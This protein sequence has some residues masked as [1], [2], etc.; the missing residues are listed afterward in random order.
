MPD[1]FI[2]KLMV[3]LQVVDD[4]RD[5]N[6][7]WDA[8]LAAFQEAAARLVAHPNAGRLDAAVTALPVGD[9]A[10]M[11]SFI[12]VVKPSDS[13]ASGPLFYE[14]VKV[15]GQW[16]VAELVARANRGYAEMRG[17]AA[18][19]RWGRMSTKDESLIAKYLGRR[20]IESGCWERTEQ[21]G[22]LYWKYW[23]TGRNPAAVDMDEASEENASPPMASQEPVDP[24]VVDVVGQPECM[25]LPS[26]D[27]SEGEQA[28]V[29]GSLETLEKFTGESNKAFDFSL[30]EHT[31]Q[32][33]A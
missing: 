20:L 8:A 27:S 29:G 12:D 7:E 15:R 32:V 28:S 1:G 26:A 5:G 17:V 18:L 31:G 21:E 23:R 30:E 2:D 4:E 19:V 11:R 33:A 24:E 13:V 22:V 16:Q 14:L 9:P 10:G 3:Q 6:Q 25:L